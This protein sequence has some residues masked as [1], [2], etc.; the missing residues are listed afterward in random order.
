MCDRNSLHSNTIKALQ[1]QSNWV[2]NGLVK[3]LLKDV[4]A[5]VQNINKKR[6]Q[7]AIT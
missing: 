5:Y 1:L 7:Q 4:K 6:Q 2:Q 3:S